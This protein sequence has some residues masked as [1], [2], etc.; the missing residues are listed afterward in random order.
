ML[1]CTIL[2]CCVVLSQTHSELLIALTKFWSQTHT[3]VS[4][5]I[6]VTWMDPPNYSSNNQSQPFIE[7]WNHETTLRFSTYLHQ[8]ALCRE[9]PKWPNS[10]TTLKLNYLFLLMQRH[11]IRGFQTGPHR[12]LQS[13]VTFSL[14]THFLSLSFLALFYLLCPLHFQLQTCPRFSVF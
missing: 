12:F 14:S 3:S 9:C 7:T 1:Y 6:E 13:T 11:E 4:S 5:K 2:L 8:P 10:V